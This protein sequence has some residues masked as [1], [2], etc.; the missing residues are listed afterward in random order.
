MQQTCVGLDVGR[1]S[2]KIVATWGKQFS[3]RKEI[4]FPSSVVPAFRLTDE[5]EIARADKETVTVDSKQYF[6]G[7]T[8][9]LQGQDDLSAGLREDWVFS[10]HHKALFLGGLK[11]LTDA[12]VP[13]IDTALVVVGLPASLYAAQKT[14]LAVELTQL[15]PRCEVKILPQSMGPYHQMMF[16]PEGFEANG[17]NPDKD[18]WAVVEIGQYTTDYAMLINGRPIENAYGSCDGMRI[19]AEQLVRTL[20]ERKSLTLELPEA[21]ETLRTKSIRNF[22]SLIDVTEEVK[23]STVPLASQIVNKSNQLLGNKVR[24]L[25]GVLVAGGGAELIYETLL[26]A[27]PHAKLTDNPRFAVADGFNRYAAAFNNYRASQVKAKKA[28]AEAEA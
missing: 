13:N 14:K 3:E 11:K 9:M 25:T 21:T 12:G 27:W 23:A 17:V 15:A 1:S 10:A 6:F 7:D 4:L 20:Q 24:E 8:A 5:M 28:A 16:T 22:G 2:V 26:Q 19:A 18:S